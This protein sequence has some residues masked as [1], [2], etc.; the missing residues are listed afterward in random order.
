MEF[1]LFL[2]VLG[3][4]IALWVVASKAKLSA[5]SNHSLVS[6]LDQEL[7]ATRSAL[8][9]RIDV[10]EEQVSKLQAGGVAA[11]PPDPEPEKEP[12]LEPTVTSLPPEELPIDEPVV[13]APPPFQPPPFQPSVPPAPPVLPSEPPPLAQLSRRIDWEE[14]IGVKGAAVLGGI[15]LALA[16]VMF[17]RYAIEHELI[18]PIV[19]VAIGFAT[20]I[21]AIAIS[22]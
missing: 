19:R 9:A 10:L 22:E 5:Q 20:G 21:A 7:Q 2:V 16:A 4:G 6:Y 8:L 17:L 18:P 14:W 13:A 15:V 11:K 12:T 3:L 1:F